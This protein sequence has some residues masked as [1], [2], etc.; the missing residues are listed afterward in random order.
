MENHPIPQDVTGFKFRLIGSMTVKQFLYVLCG[1]A[2]ALISFILPISFYIRLPLTILFGSLGAALAFVPIEGRPMDIMVINFLKALPAENLYV[3]RKK[4]AEAMIASYFTPP[5]IVKAVVEETEAEKEQKRKRALLKKELKLTKRYKPDTDE[6]AML[7]NINKY[8]DEPDFGNK[9]FNI[10]FKKVNADRVPEEDKVKEIEKLG[11]KKPAPIDESTEKTIKEVQLPV[12]PPSQMS[13]DITRDDSE[14]ELKKQKQILDERLRLVKEAEEKARVEARKIEEER[15]AREKAEEEKIAKEKA[16]IEAK[17]KK[18]EEERLAKQKAEEEAKRLEQERIAREKAEKEAR[19]ARERQE[20]EAKRLE[21]ERVAKE[22]AEAEIKAREAAEKQKAQEKAEIERLA[23]EKAEKEAQAK[24]QEEERLLK[25]RLEVE[26]RQ[27]KFNEE[28][29]ARER[30]EVEAQLQRIE[31]EREAIKKEEEERLAREREFIQ[32]QREI[33]LLKLQREADLEEIPKEKEAVGIT[34]VDATQEQKQTT[35]PLPTVALEEKALQDIIDKAAAQVEEKIENK[36]PKTPVIAQAQQ[37]VPPTRAPQQ[38]TPTPVLTQTPPVKIQ[39][40]PIGI[41]ADEQF[42]KALEELSTISHTATPAAPQPTTLTT[43]AQVVEIP[44]TTISVSP[45]PATPPVIEKTE[46]SIVPQEAKPQTPP[47]V[48]MPPVKSIAP[49]VPIEKVEEF[50][51][52][53]KPPEKTEEQKPVIQV[54]NP[55]SDAP[56]EA[57]PQAPAFT[58]PVVKKVFQ[59]AVKPGETSSVKSVAKSDQLNAGFPQLPDIPNIVLGIIKDPR[60]RVLPNVLVEILNNQ[61][62]PVRAF[63]TNGV[64]QF[65]AATPLSNGEYDVVLDDPRKTNEFEN[66]HITLNGSIF[67]PLEIFSVDAREKLRRELF[68][69]QSQQQQAA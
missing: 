12:P 58:P 50:K 38:I 41:N 64:G 68:G 65:I 31:Q 61:G 60:G 10:D 25:E 18:L 37:T 16:E 20:A 36:Q 53:I 44:A 30:A 4:G 48:S 69:G 22:K 62:V 3:Y 5:Q 15:L 9:P 1:G 6:V 51:A 42:Q 49:V 55:Q 56:E 35:E 26:E 14:E 24:I 23:R 63:K 33:E 17:A 52:P 32:K 45:L 28:K 54:V 34:T 29:L 57:S 67:Q 39:Q 11:L 40:K 13:A 19:L 7:S 27:R 46:E 66:I 59:Q 21:E 47:P 43:P 2:L 8:F